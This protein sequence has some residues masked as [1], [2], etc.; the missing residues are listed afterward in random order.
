MG[1]VEA[2]VGREDKAA[3]GRPFWSTTRTVKAVRLVLEQSRA[4]RN[5]STRPVVATTSRTT[6]LRHAP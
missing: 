3:G 1:D 2:G 6:G 4:V 5:S